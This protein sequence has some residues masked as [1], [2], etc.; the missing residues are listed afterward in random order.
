M[1]Y[2]SELP[3]S[4]KRMVGHLCTVLPLKAKLPSQ[5]FA[6]SDESV[7]ALL[8]DLNKSDVAIVQDFLMLSGNSSFIA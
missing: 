5:L 7:Y 4:S 2:S 8:N 3:V 6:F 1:S